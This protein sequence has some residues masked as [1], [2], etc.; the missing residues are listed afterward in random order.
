MEIPWDTAKSGLRTPNGMRKHFILQNLTFRKKNATTGSSTCRAGEQILPG[1]TASNYELWTN[2]FLQNQKPKTLSE[3]TG[4]QPNADRHRRGVYTQ[5]KPMKVLFF[6]F[7]YF[8]S[9][10][11][12]ADPCQ[13]CTLQLKPQEKT[14]S[15]NG[16]KNHRTFGTTTSMGKWE[17]QK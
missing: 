1:Q 5:I 4:G 2:Y 3:G 7:L 11:L 17:I 9:L 16:L 15:L 12:N 6:F 14:C 10:S 13:S 8:T